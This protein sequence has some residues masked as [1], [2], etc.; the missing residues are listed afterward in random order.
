MKQTVEEAARE[1]LQSI[2]EDTHFEVNFNEDN[3]DAGARN[4]MF[5]V[6][7]PSFKAGA[8]WH[9][10]QSFDQILEENKDVLKQLKDK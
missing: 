8:E 10:R 6:I 4:A 5:D 7:E 1:Y 9:A 3:Y 2:I